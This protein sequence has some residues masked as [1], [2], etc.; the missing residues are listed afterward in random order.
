MERKRNKKIKILLVKDNSGDA[1]LSWVMF[2]EIQE[3]I[4]ILNWI[5]QRSIILL[6]FNGNK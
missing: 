6:R 5:K 1:N 3:R 4:V 2:S